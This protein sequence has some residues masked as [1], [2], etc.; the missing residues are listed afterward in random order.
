MM[1][2][3]FTVSQLERFK[4]D[5]VWRYMNEALQ[6]ELKKTRGMLDDV[7]TDG[8]YK[9]QGIIAGIKDLQNTIDKLFEDARLSALKNAEQEGDSD[10]R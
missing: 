2:G 5:P 8:L 4:Q 3:S 6:D 9:L 1:E 10:G 7:D